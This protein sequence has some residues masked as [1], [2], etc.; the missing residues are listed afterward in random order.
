M[1]TDSFNGWCDGYNVIS[2]LPQAFHIPVVQNMGVIVFDRFS[3][4]IGRSG[5]IT[6]V[7]PKAAGSSLILKLTSAMALDIIKLTGRNTDL[8]IYSFCTSS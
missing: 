6:A 2:R 8:V 4:G 7:Q 1:V 3:H 5:D